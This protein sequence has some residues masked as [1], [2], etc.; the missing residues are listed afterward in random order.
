[1]RLRG[2]RLRHE[3]TANPRKANSSSLSPPGGG[4]GASVCGARGAVGHGWPLLPG[5][6]VELL[7]VS[8]Q[9][10]SAPFIV[11]VM[12]RRSGIFRLRADEGTQLGTETRVQTFR[13]AATMT[14]R[15]Y[16]LV[17]W[18]LFRLPSEGH[19]A[20]GPT[21]LRAILGL[22]E[23]VSQTKFPAETD[24]PRFPTPDGPAPS[25]FFY[26]FS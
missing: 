17:R 21:G 22:S 16:R 13:R 12:P 9:R 23:D 11:T 1:M 14:F 24:D 8:L 3:K 2:Y 4:C 5:R 15:P 18:P 25:A 26:P 7:L 19:A 20:R 10:N 6:M